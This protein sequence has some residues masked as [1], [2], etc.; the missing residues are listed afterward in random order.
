MLTVA[1]EMTGKEMPKWF[2]MR[3]PECQLEESLEDNS[4]IVKRAFETYID[5]N[6]RN[7]LS[8]WQRTEAPADKVLPL[9]E[10]ISNRFVK[11]V[12]SKLLAD[13]KEEIMAT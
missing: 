5:I 13:V 10:E 1:Y 11:L 9:P 2:N 8:F 12:D 4:V 6:F 7:S 3:L